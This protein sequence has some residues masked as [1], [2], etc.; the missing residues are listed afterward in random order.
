[1]EHFSFYQMIPGIVCLK[2]SCVNEH[3][4]VYNDCRVVNQLSENTVFSKAPRH[5]I[6]RFPGCK[7]SLRGQPRDASVSGLSRSGNGMGR[8]ICARE[9]EPPAA[10]H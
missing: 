1:M 7:Y 10:P 3:T 2:I 9:H 6:C 5:G 4:C 8:I